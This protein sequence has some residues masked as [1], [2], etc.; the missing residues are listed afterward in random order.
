MPHPSIPT[1]ITADA[2]PTSK[3]DIYYKLYFLLLKLLGQFC[4]NR[5]LF[6]KHPN[7]SCSRFT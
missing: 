2:Q 1:D 4:F 5:A 7:S 3:G 6:P